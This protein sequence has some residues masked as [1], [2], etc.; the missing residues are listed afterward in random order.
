[1]LDALLTKATAEDLLAE[2][3]RL[4]R[5]AEEAEAEKR[6]APSYAG[7]EKRFKKL[8]PGGASGVHT[9]MVG[10]ELITDKARIDSELNSYWGKVFQAQPIE[11]RDKLVLQSWLDDHLR[12]MKPPEGFEAE[13]NLRKV[14]AHIRNTAPGPDGIPYAAYKKCL[15]LCLPI[16]VDAWGWLWEGSGAIRDFVSPQK[17]PVRTQ[18][19]GTSTRLRTRDR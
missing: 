12:Q 5:D 13:P 3:D 11:D 8:I 4:A 6:P 18:L 16:F 10:G 14:I 15:D 19:S 1:M 9:L 2:A 17:L 7:I